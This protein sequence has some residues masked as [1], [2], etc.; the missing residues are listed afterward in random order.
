MSVLILAE[1]IDLSADQMVLALAEREVATHRIN[2]AWFPAELAVEAQWS[3]KGWEGRLQSPRGELDLEEIRSI[4]FRSPAA[5]QFPEHLSAAER[6]HCYIETKL[7]MGGV[8]LALPV[9]WVNRPDLAATACYKPIQIAAAGRAGL[10][11]PPTLVTNTASAVRRFAAARPGPVVTKMFASNSIVE[12]GKRGVAFT[13]Q[14]DAADL[15]D[16]AGVEVTAHQFQ[17]RIHPKAYDARVVV[18]GDRQFGFAIHASTPQAQL[19]FRRDYAALSYERVDVPEPVAKGVADLMLTLGLVYAAIDFVV[20]PTGEWV[21]IGDV[22]PGGQF[23][24]LEAATDAPLT[25]CLADLLSAGLA[26]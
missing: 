9:L 16:L 10:T 1:D 5:F 7:G 22:N 24:W 8:L 2:M 14:L 4:W 11:V 18:I 20:E 19:D 15:A 23:G 12:D 13:R 17:R 6:Q 21:F 26:A 25:D 3:G